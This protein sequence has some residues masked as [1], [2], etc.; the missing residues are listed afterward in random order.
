MKFV[1]EFKIKDGIVSKTLEKIQENRLMRMREGQAAGELVELPSS[2]EV[3][4][5]LVPLTDGEYLHSMK[6]ADLEE[7]GENAAGMVVRD[8]V[9]KQALLMYCCRELD[10]WQE[11]VFNSIAEIQDALE[12][13]DVEIL[14]DRYLEMIQQISPSLYMMEDGEFENLKVIWQQIRWNELSGMQQYAAKRFLRLIQGDL[15]QGNSYGSPSTLKS[16]QTIDE[17]TPVLPADQRK[18]TVEESPL[19]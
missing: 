16:T 11:R 4:L 19:V 3:R 17:P 15:L 1:P 18:I 7:A 5:L 8:R 13:A 9:Q 10:N 2:P 12:V 6:L 14:Y